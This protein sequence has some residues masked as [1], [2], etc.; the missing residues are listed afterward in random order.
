MT[1]HDLAIDEHV[2]EAATAAVVLRMVEVDKRYPG[3]YALKSVS[4]DV[5]QGEVHALVGENGAGKSTLVGIAAGSVTSDSGHVEIGG[6]VISHPT[7]EACREAGLAIVY[8]EPALLPDLTVAENMRLGMPSH[9]RPTV[10]VQNDWA[11]GI[12]A[13]WAK[14]ASI[15][16]RTPVREMKPDERF[17]VEIARAMA[18]DPRVVI[19]D[20]P[21]E[22]LLPA[23]VAELFTLVDEAKAR[24]AAIVYI[25]HR[26]NE[27]KQIADRISVL[28]DGRLEGTF[29]GSDVSEQ[30]VV[31]LVVG[32]QVERVQRQ[33]RLIAQSSPI[34]LDVA[35][36][37][38]KGFT[39]VSL[40]VRRGEILGLAGIEGQGQR[41]FMRALAGLAKSSGEV[42]VN[43]SRAV[44]SSVRRAQSSGIAYLTHDR[45]NEGVLARLSVSE[46][47]AISAIGRFARATFVSGR[48]ERDAVAREFESMRVK[49]PTLETDI[50]ALSGGNQQKV[51]LSRVLLVDA[52]V[53]LV[54]EPTQGVDVGARAEIY[55]ILRQASASGKTVVVLSS[56]AA[57]LA[58]LCDRVVVFSRGEAV[59]QLLGDDISE[60]SITQ[61]AL[62]ATSSRVETQSE[63]HAETATLWRKFVRS[64]QSPALVLLTLT[65]ILGVVAAVQNEFYLTTRNF[66]LLLPLLAVL[67]FFA[68]AQQVVMMIGAI[69]L[70]VGPLAG[71]L[72]V[73]ASF[74]LTPDATGMGLVVGLLIVIGVAVLVGVLNWSLVTYAHINPLIATLVTYTGIQ[75]IAFL[76]RPLP[77]GDISETVVDIAKAKIGFVPVFFVG[78]VVLAL[79]LEFALRRSLL[80][81]RF[82]AVG[83]ND[84]IARKVGVNSKLIALA[85][86][87]GCSVVVVPAAILLMAQARTGNATIGDTYVLASIAAV[88]LGGASIFGGRGSFLGAI[89]GAVLFTQM[90]TV[91][92]FLGLDLYWQ[93]WL[94]GGLTIIAAA[95]Y[96]KTRSLTERA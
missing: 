28:R 44:V 71:L 42:R 47:A 75:G 31:N 3:V 77:G 80:G 1:E 53:I 10:R 25:S 82:R 51:M 83:S 63:S 12:L 67:A 69:D 48:R 33:S 57:E 2:T 24:G 70:S 55:E 81:V 20:E 62:T 65:V 17:V 56:S 64:D 84:G 52:D 91:V 29:T 85:A 43:G 30:E 23:A 66:G 60:H 6:E 8:Q 15:D 92:Q 21:T 11:A 76:L 86:F 49:T 19:L 22:H 73:V 96:S 38:G 58:E 35:G 50:D 61:T 94:L 59:R 79:A 16:P 68:L 54:D 46:N 27:V 18:E 93:L 37:T 34:S 39:S 90:N 4:F 95:F 9:L 45:H 7:P 14:V 74:V 72:V 89:M 26:L 40:D 41:D 87:V 88:V 13:P 5:R 78:A 32:R 36:L